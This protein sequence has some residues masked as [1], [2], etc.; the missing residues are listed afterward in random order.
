[1]ASADQVPELSDGQPTKRGRVHERLLCG[2][3]GFNQHLG[4]RGVLMQQERGWRQPHVDFVADFLRIFLIRYAQARGALPVSFYLCIGGA[5]PAIEELKAAVQAEIDRHGPELVQVVQTILDHPEP[6]FREW[7]T[8]AATAKKFRDFGIPFDDGIALTGLKGRLDSGTPGPTVGVIGELDS[9]KVLGHP[10]ADP[11]D[12]GR[13][14]LWSSL[15]SGHDA[16]GGDRAPGG[17]G[18]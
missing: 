4:V 2:N 1:M 5:M 3:D 11:R 15:P 13:A 18:A 10:H 14:C 6:G 17:R 12:I 7:K 16:R 9:L 8:S